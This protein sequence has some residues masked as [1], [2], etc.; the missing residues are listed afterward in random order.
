MVPRQASISVCCPKPMLARRR[1]QATLSWL[2]SYWFFSLF[3]A[4]YSE[5][6]API[7]VEGEVPD[8]VAEAEGV[9]GTILRLL[10]I[11][12]LHRPKNRRG[13]QEQA[14]VI[15]GGPQAIRTKPGVL[16]S[17]QG[18]PLELLQVISPGEVAGHSL[19]QQK[20]VLRQEDGLEEEEAVELDHPLPGHPTRVPASLVPDTRAP[21]LVGLAVVSRSP[22]R[23]IGLSCY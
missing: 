4:D 5:P 18:L 10:T 2:F 9:V 13:R 20:G 6:G 1:S 14:Q 16:D 8:E 22:A 19:H 21:A 3:S 15:L 17:G 12:A 7:Q 11:P 23:S